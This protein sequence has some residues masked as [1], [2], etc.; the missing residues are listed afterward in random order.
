MNTKNISFLLVFNLIVYLSFAQ[1][2]VGNYI[3]RD[4]NRNNFQ[5]EPVTEGINGVAVELWSSTNSIH[6][7][8]DDVYI[9]TVVSADST[10]GFPG[11]YKFN[12]AVS[13]NYY[14]KFPVSNG[15]EVL[16]GQDLNQETDMNSDADI[17]GVSPVFYINT[18]GFGGSRHNLTID[19]GYMSCI[20]PTFTVS[21]VS[22]TCA[23]SH[24]NADGKILISGIT[25]AN[26][27]D[28]SAGDTYIGMGYFFAWDLGM[29]VNG[30]IRTN[31]PAS[32]NNQTYTVRLFNNGDNCHTDHIVTIPALS[33][34]DGT[35]IVDNFTTTKLFTLQ[36]GTGSARASY[37]TGNGVGEELDIKH[38]VLP[39]FFESDRVETLG[40]EF[41]MALNITHGA[42][43]SGVITLQWD[44]IDGDAD[45]INYT[46]LGGIDITSGGKVDRLQFELQSDFSNNDTLF[47][48]ISLYSS[49]TAASTITLGLYNENGLFNSYSALYSAFTP[50]I[51]GGVDFQ[52]IGAIQMVIDASVR[53]GMDIALSSFRFPA[54]SIF[55]VELKDFTIS[56]DVSGA[57]L[58]WTT[59]TEVNTSHF[60]VERSVDN[61]LSFEAIASIPAAGNSFLP[62][63]YRF[64]DYEVGDIGSDKVFYR[65]KMIDIDNSFTYSN[66]VALKLW[67]SG[68]YFKL[69][70]SP[71]QDKLNVAYK[72]PN[73]SVPTLTIFNVHGQRVYQEVF[74]VSTAGSVNLW[75]INVSDLTSGVYLLEMVTEDRMLTQ[76]FIIQ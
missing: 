35:I 33:C 36:G 57:T 14:V 73:I 30:E 44:G 66:V 4:L 72:A 71:V 19:A 68:I 26:R 11:Y 63:G 76:K 16:T 45:A 59:V 53:D 24:S 58:N 27:Y 22:P 42:T 37:A 61:G 1:G 74:E 12:I 6:G 39:A 25:D 3:W 51:G 5:D 10:P 46:G 13:G 64:K 18:A 47:V 54:T 21:S 41:M 62:K 69:F 28:I 52:N 38:E 15:G 20:S 40:S 23:G 55:P 7:D 49:N 43:T 32:Y 70:P 75:D 29:V 50:I 17:D 60:S 48:T 34:G 65:L 2:T 31:I 56:E 9:A 67:N 8:A